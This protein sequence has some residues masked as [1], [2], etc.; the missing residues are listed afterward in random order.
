MKS[1]MELKQAI[2]TLR[3]TLP[4]DFIKFDKKQWEF[5]AL[6]SKT[7]FIAWIEYFDKILRELDGLV[8]DHAKTLPELM[9]MVDDWIKT[10][11]EGV[12]GHQDAYNKARDSRKFIE[13]SKWVVVGE[14][15]AKKQ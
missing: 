8:K 12:M 6:G 3:E 7:Q 4:I 14:G 13:E 5:Y 11:Q 9:Q 15:E 1:L 10:F 2:Q